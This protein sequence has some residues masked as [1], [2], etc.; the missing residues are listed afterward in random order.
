MIQD[1]AGRGNR[2]SGEGSSEGEGEEEGGTCTIMKLFG[3][4]NRGV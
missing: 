3:F 1:E 2:G 4:T